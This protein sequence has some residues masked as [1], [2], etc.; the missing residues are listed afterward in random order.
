[1]DKC[2]VNADHKFLIEHVINDDGR[3]RI[4]GDTPSALGPAILEEIPEVKNSVRMKYTHADFRYKDKVF[5]EQI[6][7]AD[8]GFM[9][10]F[11]Y[12]L[13]SGTQDVLKQ[14]DRIAISKNI[15]K[16]Y[17]GDEDPLGKQVSVVY[18]VNGK[19]YKET[20]I[21]GAVADDFDY[22][23]TI[24]FHILIPFE[25][26]RNF[27]L[28]EDNDWFNKT[29]AT[30][31]EL[32]SA[33][34]AEHVIQQLNRYTDLQNEA[35]P[36]QK[37]SHFL[38][39]P[40]P[41]M[42]LDAHGKE[43]MIVYNAPPAARIFLTIIAIF[44]LV[45]AVFNYINIAVVSATSRLKEIGLR[46]TIGGTRSQ[47]IV[48][49][50]SENTL[51]CFLALIF[52][53]LL[54][55]GFTLPGFNGIASNNSPLIL[56]FSNPRLWIYIISLFLLISIGSAAYPAFYITGF[57][58]VHILKGNLTIAS[59]NYFAKTLLGLQFIISFITISLSVVFVLND[60]YGQK[61]D[62]GYNKEYAIVVPLVNNDQYQ[63]LH[64]AISQNPDIQIISGS[65]NH[66]GYWTE[67]DALLYDSK[68]LLSKKILAGYE[69]L[70]VMGMRLKE[71]RFFQPNSSTDMKESIVVNEALVRQLEIE[72]P[73]GARLTLNEK[74]CYIIG[75]VEDFHYLDF[76][77]EIKPIFFKLTDKN[78]F[79]FLEFRTKPGRAVVTEN[80][81]EGIWKNMYPDNT[82]EGFFQNTAFDTF[83][84]E[85]KSIS[86]I[87]IAIAAMAIIISSMGLFGLV[88]LYITKRLKEF[89]IRKVMGASLKELTYQVSRGFIWVLIV[90]SLLGIPFAYLLSSFIITSLYTYHVPVDSWPFIFTTFILLMTALITVSTQVARAI[91]VNPVDQ[92]R[93]E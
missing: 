73:I 21:I 89:S 10:M 33:D 11:T 15:A 53:Y 37:I 83:F 64:D 91:G 22:M 90:G 77:H 67:E 63:E 28:F 75:V 24:R 78:N 26:R 76:G 55:V 25:N 51:L 70:D 87:M 44:I 4:F 5:S 58:P 48:Q 52:G 39:D 85:N 9:D 17:F 13:L 23:T 19:D 49:F 79:S 92:L 32:Q 6:I 56:D 12:E 65:Q 81:V 38:L 7:F 46:K 59:K 69:Y 84:R 47:L 42:A 93:N 68:Q 27:G 82:Y 88:S 20:Y 66:M 62:W 50:I 16:K 34:Q 43:N 41:R 45:L 1:M 40:L 60:Q 57:R 80:Y 3:E 74:A 18:S 14:K 36:D 8:K 35:N 86:K 54:T 2:H 61:R 29:N 30:F 31:V 72:E 71:G